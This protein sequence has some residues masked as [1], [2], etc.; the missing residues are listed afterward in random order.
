MRKAVGGP[1]SGSGRRWGDRSREA[2]SGG[3][4]LSEVSSQAG[5]PENLD[6]AARRCRRRATSRREGWLEGRGSPA[7]VLL[8]GERDATDRRSDGK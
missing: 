1:L 3:G 4:D 6:K 2:G 8:V 7:A 5:G